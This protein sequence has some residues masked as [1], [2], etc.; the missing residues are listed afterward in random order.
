MPKTSTKQYGRVLSLAL[1]H[2][3]AI[4]PTMLTTIATVMARHVAGGELAGEP[5]FVPREPAPAGSAGGGVYVIPIHGVIAPR[6]NLFSDISGGATFEEATQQLR[7][8]VAAPGVGTIVLDWDS[9]GGSAA[10]A[11]EFARELLKATTVKPVISHANF[12]M[13][14]GA[15]WTGACATEVIASPSAILGSIGVYTLHEDLSK[16]LADMGITLTYVSAGKYKVDGNPAEPLSDTARARLTALVNA[17][18]ERFV[19]DVAEG[20]GVSAAAVKSGYGEGTVLNADEALAAGL[21]DR[22]ETFDDTV[23]RLLREPTP[24][25]R[26]MAAQTEMETALHALAW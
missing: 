2:P 19:A 4:T 16:A 23:A 18:Y 1:E 6:M 3:W 24:N 7:E 12:Q 10:G 25:S 5:G 17:T 14:S 20:R 13:C 9:P 8:A 26:R 21:I 11:T 15:Y 22:I